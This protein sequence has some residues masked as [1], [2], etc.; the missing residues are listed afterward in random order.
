VDEQ[1][2]FSAGALILY[3]IPYTLMAA[4]TYGS[5]VPSGDSPP[6]ENQ[7]PKE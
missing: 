3:F 5:A 6:R 1:P 2:T 7:R 4:L